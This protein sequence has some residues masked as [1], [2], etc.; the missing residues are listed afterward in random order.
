MMAMGLDHLI[1]WVDQGKLPPRAD[2]I[3]VENGAIVLDAYGNAKGGVRNPYVDVPVA[4]YGV[5]NAAT[6]NRANVQINGQQPASFYCGIAGFE[7]PMKTSD[8]AQRY[9]TP[10]NYRK[11]VNQSLKDATKAGWFLPVYSKQVESD[12]MKIDFH[13]GVAPLSEAHPH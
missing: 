3:Q 1:Q 9:L 13:R 7:F 2:R 4:Q 11:Q 10:A 12:A 8:V 6:G 5:P